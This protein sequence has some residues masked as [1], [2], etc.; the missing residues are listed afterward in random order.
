MT[1]RASPALSVVI[2]PLG[3]ASLL[4]SA[5]DAVMRERA[6]V[7]LEIIVPC[8][9]AID[10]L[11]DSFGAERQTDVL[12][13]AADPGADTW[14][15]RSVGVAAASGAVVATI[16]DQTIPE[17]GWAAAVVAAHEAPHAAVGGAV[18][19]GTPDSVVGWAMYFFDYWRYLAPEAGASRFLSACNVSYKREAL[20]RIAPLWSERMHETDVHEALAEHGGTLWLEPRMAVR[21]RRPLVFRAALRELF[22][23]GRLYGADRAGS[24]SAGARVVRVVGL[25]ALP[26]LHLVRVGR[27][28]Q[29][30]PRLFPRFVVAAPVIT[31]LALSWSLGE[32]RGLMSGA[33]RD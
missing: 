7:P 26:V 10:R 25:P 4:G 30:V 8:T 20:A 15:L 17:P 29:R 16:E 3:D 23:H 22:R 28:V 19:K 21:Q 9:P 32:L 33:P 27:R 2:V 14:A 11:L 24:L 18:H 13:P 12:R 31:A 5:L 1:E 6:H